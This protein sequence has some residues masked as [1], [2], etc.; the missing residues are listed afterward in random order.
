MHSAGRATNLPS[1]THCT[2]APALQQQQQAAA[3]E[4][5]CQAAHSGGQPMVAAGLQLQLFQRV[6]V[7]G[8][9]AWCVWEGRCRIQMYRHQVQQMQVSKAWAQGDHSWAMDTRCH[10]IAGCMG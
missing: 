5:L 7:V 2:D 1:R 4:L 8:V 3:A 6:L 9:I 10:A